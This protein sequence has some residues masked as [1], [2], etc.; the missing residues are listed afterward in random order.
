M[1]EGTAFF[2]SVFDNVSTPVFWSSHTFWDAK[3]T[4]QGSELGYHLGTITWNLEDDLP[5]Q[6]GKF[7]GSMLIL[8]GVDFVLIFGV[9][10]FQPFILINWRGLIA[11]KIQFGLSDQ[12]LKYAH[13][14]LQPAKWVDCSKQWSWDIWPIGRGF[15]HFV[16]SSLPGELIQ[17]VAWECRWLTSDGL[18]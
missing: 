8:C 14:N 18:F 9:S 4:I 13:S 10:N 2:G 7:L 1:V 16:F 17:L 15:N 5:F 3:H 11:A 6:W 12:S